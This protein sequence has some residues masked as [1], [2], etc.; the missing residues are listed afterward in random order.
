MEAKHINSNWLAYVSFKTPL[1]LERGT[2]RCHDSSSGSRI[3]INNNKE[4]KKVAAASV[5]KSNNNKKMKK[6]N[7]NIT[8]PAR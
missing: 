7:K 8:E 4:N 5:E 3:N 2:V 1:E 6:R